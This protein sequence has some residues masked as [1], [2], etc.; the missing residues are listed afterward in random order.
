MH[1]HFL[2]CTLLQIARLPAS[3]LALQ[4]LNICAFPILPPAV[5]LSLS[6]SLSLCVRHIVHLENTQSY[7]VS[8]PEVLIHP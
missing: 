5:T 1:Q 8:Y 4:D 2:T 6:L 3:A 7:I